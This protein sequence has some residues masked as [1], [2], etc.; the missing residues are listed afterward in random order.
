MQERLD[1]SIV[2][3]KGRSCSRRDFLKLATAGVVG[4][5]VVGW[6]RAGR[7][8]GVIIC[9]RCSAEFAEGHSHQ[10]GPVQG[11]YCP[12]CGVELSRLEYDLRRQSKLNVAKRNPG[13]TDCVWASAQVPFPNSS[14]VRRTDKPTLVL[15]DLKI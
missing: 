5:G 1:N 8:D 3:E 9:S 2:R 11:V 4:V 6:L 7:A 10:A 14:R 15:S 12:N 13:K